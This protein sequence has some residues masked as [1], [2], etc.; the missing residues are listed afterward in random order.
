M[1]VYTYQIIQDDGSEGDTFELVRAMTDPP[2]THHPETGERVKRIFAAPHVPG[3]HG[4]SATK[5]RL[6]NENL[7]RH[8]FTKYERVGKGQYE[9]RAGNEGPSTI[10]AD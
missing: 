9:R 2:L 6:S 1:P 3:R 10:S 5:A 4:A 7:E 8:G